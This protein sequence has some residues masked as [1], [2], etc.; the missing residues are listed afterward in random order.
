MLNFLLLV[1][2]LGAK[3]IHR[4]FHIINFHI[5]YPQLVYWRPLRYVIKT[6]VLIFEH[7]SAYHFNFGVQKKLP[8]IQAIFTCG[9]PLIGVSR[10]LIN[11]IEAFV[12][13]KME[14]A[15]V[16]PNIVDTRVFTYDKRIAVNP[17]RFLMISQW[18]QPKRP[19]IVIKAFAK[20][21]ASHPMEGY[22][23][24]IAGYGMQLA[25]MKE[26]ADSLNLF[27]SVVFLGALDSTTIAF[28]LNQCGALLHCSEYET[29]SVVCAESISCG[30]PVIASAVGGITEFIDSANGKLVG[31]N[32]E[33][34]WLSALL[35]FNTEQFDRTSI[36][37]RAAARFSTQAVGKGYLAI[38]KGVCDAKE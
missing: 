6:P 32:T 19:D 36:S 3:R 27:D 35:E 37:S 8:R 17:R 18:R 10:S 15:F 14:R 16:L 22:Q 12:G 7:W 20:L 30:A 26:L 21:V 5:A 29:F 9:L 1:Y 23:L 31:E 4:D 2:Y 33:A 38:L 28:E 24:R 11:D 13:Q 34:Q 25:E